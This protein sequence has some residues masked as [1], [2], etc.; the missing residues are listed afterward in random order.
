M[1]KLSWEEAQ[2]LFTNNKNYFV[3]FTTTW[4]P[5]CQMMKKMLT[6]IIAKK[7]AKQPI[8]FIEIDAEKA[9]LF[10][11]NENNWQVAKVPSLYI[12]KNNQQKFIGYEYIPMPVI[13]E[14]IDKTLAL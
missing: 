7:Y 4:C 11:K 13:E 14:A 8:R 9:N 6:P 12:V 2:K 1:E 3:M 5:D 10:R